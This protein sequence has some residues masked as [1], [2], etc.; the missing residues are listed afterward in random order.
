MI[1]IEYFEKQKSRGQGLT[2]KLFEFTLQTFGHLIEKSFL[3]RFL[4]EMQ[5]WV[6]FCPKMQALKEETE[7]IAEKVFIDLRIIDSILPAQFTFFELDAGLVVNQELRSKL[8][9]LGFN[10]LA[11]INVVIANELFS[12]RKE[13]EDNLYK[14][15]Y[16]VIKMKNQKLKV[17]QSV[18]ILVTQLNESNILMQYFGNKLKELENKPLNEY[19]QSV[20]GYAQGNLFWSTICK[21]YNKIS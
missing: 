9:W 21:R 1:W 12:L 8:D 3:K 14:F 20:I 16:V 6:A 10:K 19:V 18:D 17:Q 15:N 4:C 2:E 11:A 5:K 7:T 13:I